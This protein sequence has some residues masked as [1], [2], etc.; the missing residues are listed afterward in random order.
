MP[1]EGMSCAAC[2]LNV[3]R[4][5]NR[6]DGIKQA[7]VNFAFGTAQVE[8]DPTKINA[9]T[10]VETV[11]DAGYDAATATTALA[12][13]GMTCAA[14]VARVEKALTKVNGVISAS[15]NLATNKATITYI[16]G[17][18]TVADFKD[19]VE[20]AGY[21]VVEAG[22]EESLEDRERAARERELASLTHSFIISAALTV[23]IVAA[24]MFHMIPGAPHIPMEIL[25]PILFVLTTPVQFWAGW[26]FY[27]GA[28]S[29][30]RHHTTDMNTLVAVGTLAA[31]LYSTVATF[32][33]QVLVLAGAEP[34]VY[35]ESS[36]TIITLILLGRLLEARARGRTSEAI[37]RL[38]GRHARTA[39]VLRDGVEKDIP[40]ETV[41][42]GDL[43]IVR[44]GEKIPVD[45]KITAG[46]SA[47]DE[48]MVTGESIPVEKAPGDEVI[49][50]TINRTGSFTFQALR[51]G[52][53]TT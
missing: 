7:N 28:W 29:A 16:P 39:R 11:R 48:S 14:C 47:V 9:A 36:A 50:A 32:A 34:A 25:N 42:V 37:R 2:A 31:Y 23:V 40:I 8:F 43:V 52:K 12:I 53:E 26:R 46:H 27:R 24:S 44:P 3:E 38:M 5:L 35:F 1:I 13:T 20:M 33:P 51:V 19:A 6:K 4:A 41:E 22:A 49:G 10:L 15:V 45:G 30:A 17:V 21:S 18:A